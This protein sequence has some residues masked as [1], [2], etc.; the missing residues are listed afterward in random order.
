MEYYS[1]EE[2]KQMK[3]QSKFNKIN[4]KLNAKQLEKVYKDSSSED[5]KEQ[6]KKASSSE[7]SSEPSE[8]SGSEEEVV[9]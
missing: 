1:P 5:E 9:V 4:I 7:E 8:S 3:E 6:K 2:P